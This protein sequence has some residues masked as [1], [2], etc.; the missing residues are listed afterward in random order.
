MNLLNIPNTFK[1][2][3]LFSISELLIGSFFVIFVYKTT[4]NIELTLLALALYY[5][6]LLVGCIIGYVLNLHE[7]R[8][9]S[10][11]FMLL[12]ILYLITATFYSS[13]STAIL[14]FV[15]IYSTILGIYF[16]G[17]NLILMDDL[18]DESKRH[19]FFFAAGSIIKILSIFLPVFSGFLIS[20][21]GYVGIFATAGILLLLAGFVPFSK[22]KRI[23]RAN[24]FETFSQIWARKGPRGYL[25][26]LAGSSLIDELRNISLFLVPFFLLGKSEFAI[27]L[28]ISA[29]ALISAIGAFLMRNKK[30][31]QTRIYGLIGTVFISFFNLLLGVV[32]SGFSLVLRS[33]GI[34]I[35]ET[36]MNP[37]IAND[38]LALNENLM[39]NIDKDDLEPYLLI[40]EIIFFLSRITAL[41]I[42]TAIFWFVERDYVSVSRILVVLFAFWPTAGFVIRSWLLGRK[43]KAPVLK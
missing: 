32:W 28:L 27:G 12:G 20:E 10:I 24:V 18:K 23:K 17:Q 33:F 40:K 16:L 39:R 42:Y 14:I 13:V 15:F 4:Y 8:Y 37:Q 35:S 9:V 6:G 41:L 22:T 19:S 30:N 21:Y 43:I 11:A 29:A 36:I 38:D 2:R 1:S 34:S 31:K 25:R 7:T 3:L 26:F 5:F